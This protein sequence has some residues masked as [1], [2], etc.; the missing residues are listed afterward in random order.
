MLI[1]IP[2]L[3]NAAQ[4]QKIHELLADANFVDGK[5]TAGMAARRVKENEELESVPE[6]QQRVNRIIMAA[7]AHNVRFRSFALPNKMADFIVARYQ[8]GMHYGDHVDDPIMGGGKFRTDVSTTI[9]LNERQNI[10]K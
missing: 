9:F 6:L 1:E 3:L 8:P 5:L 4:V 7:I 10:I 2:E